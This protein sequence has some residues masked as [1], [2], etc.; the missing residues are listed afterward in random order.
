MKYLLAVITFLLV[1]AFSEVDALSCY[2]CIYNVSDGAPVH[3]P[4][5]GDPFD[6]EMIS[7]ETCS[8]NQYCGKWPAF[9]GDR[10]GRFLV[11]LQRGC[12]ANTGDGCIQ[13]EDARGGYLRICGYFCAEN[14]CNSTMPL[15]LNILV[16]FMTLIFAMLVML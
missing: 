13:W 14:E 8:E 9:L 6:G 15:Q 5:C 1:I 4:R 2:N 11:S 3:N 12:G 10:T 7:T 16:V